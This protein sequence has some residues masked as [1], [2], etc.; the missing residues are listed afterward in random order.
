ML[1]EHFFHLSMPVLFVWRENKIKRT[2][3]WCWIRWL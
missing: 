1:L 2:F 3:Q